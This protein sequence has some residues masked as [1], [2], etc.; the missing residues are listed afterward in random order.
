MNVHF[1]SNPCSAPTCLRQIDCSCLLSAPGSE[2]TCI[3]E[4]LQ[5]VA[6]VSLLS[7]VFQDWFA[8]SHRQ[9]TATETSFH[10]MRALS[11]LPRVA[12]SSSSLLRQYCRP[13]FQSSA[14]QR[15]PLQSL[16]YGHVFPQRTSIRTMS[17][18]LES[19]IL[20]DLRELPFDKWEW[21]IYRCSYSDD[22]TWARLRARIEAES[23]ESIAMS[24]APEILDHLEWTWLEDRTSLDGISTTELRKRF[25]KW[26]SDEVAR[27]PGDYDP[28]KSR[29]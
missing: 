18:S 17:T 16:V 29:A 15:A 4:Y 11:L 12:R 7:P 21:V 27:H 19:G 5:E 14:I 25:R 13:T 28:L 1:F 9:P 22:E 26:A 10:R 6:K 3:S 24:D 2:S 23:R 20:Q 8:I